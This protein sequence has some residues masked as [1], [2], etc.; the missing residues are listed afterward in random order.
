MI[1]VGI[2]LF[3]TIGGWIGAVMSHNNWFGVWSLVLSTVGS[4]FGVWAGYKAAQ[5]MG[6]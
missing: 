6:L 3:G 1:F 5:Y 2:T 4:L